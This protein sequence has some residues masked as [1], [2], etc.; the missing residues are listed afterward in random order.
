MHFARHYGQPIPHGYDGASATARCHQEL[1]RGSAREGGSTGED[2][3]HAT[4]RTGAADRAV[5]HRTRTEPTE[6]FYACRAKDRPRRSA[7]YEDPH[8]FD[9]AK[10]LCYADHAQRHPRRAARCKAPH[11]PAL[12]HPALRRK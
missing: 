7:Q 5:G 2:G 9:R 11:G 8:G 4:G 6:Q 1:A 3:H 12:R 10:E